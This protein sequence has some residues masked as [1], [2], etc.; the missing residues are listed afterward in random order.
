MSNLSDSSLG[1]QKSGRNSK[2]KMQQLLVF[3]GTSYSF[4]FYGYNREMI[5]AATNV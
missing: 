5:N 2:P 3:I 4:S 1:L